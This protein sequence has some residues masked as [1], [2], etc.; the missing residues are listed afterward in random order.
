[1]AQAQIL[2]VEDE[3]IVARDIERCLQGL[4]YG[5]PAIASSGEDAIEKA[6]EAAIQEKRKSP[7]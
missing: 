1:M 7:Q 3:N 5:V 2:V 6:A 4:G